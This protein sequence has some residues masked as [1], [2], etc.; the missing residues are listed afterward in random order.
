MFSAQAQLGKDCISSA[1]I[2]GGAAIPAPTAGIGSVTDAV[3]NLC[4][5]TQTESGLAW[6]N[7]TWVTLVATTAGTIEMNFDANPDA[8]IDMVAWNVGNVD[9]A[10][11][12]GALPASG[13]NIRCDY[14]AD[15][16]ASGFGATTCGTSSGCTDSSA[17]GGT[18]GALTVAVG[19]RIIAMVSDYDIF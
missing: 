11:G 8:D 19:D 9:L 6:N 12:C 10:T 17:N 18:D 5:G 7:T 1:N 2:C 16:G 3:P 13:T 14:S 4:A 15:S